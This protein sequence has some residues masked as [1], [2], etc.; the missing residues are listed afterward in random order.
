L[1]EAVARE[2]PVIG[3]YTVLLGET[4]MR[5]QEG[6]HLRRDQI[7]VGPHEKMV[8]IGKTKSGRVRS[9][10]LSELAWQWLDQLVRFL[11][12]EYVFVDPLRRKRWKDPRGPFD[13]GKKAAGLSW[14]TF[15]G[16]RYVLSQI[17]FLVSTSG[18]L[19]SSLVFY[20]N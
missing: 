5:K 10:P 2:D 18:F 15:H 13:R 3:A 17:M 19:F 12:I 8:I 6:L 7:H 14:V 1:I 20:R 16:L 4:G 9:V 11:D